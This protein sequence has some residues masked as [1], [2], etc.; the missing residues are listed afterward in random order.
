MTVV[1][2]TDHE[3]HSARPRATASG[4]P[5]SHDERRHADFVA[6]ADLLIH[7]AQYTAAEY[8]KQRGWGHSTGRIRRRRWRVAGK[9]AT[10]RALPPRSAA[11]RRRRR[12]DRRA[13]PANGRAEPA[14]RRLRGGRRPGDR[15]RRPI[16]DARPHARV[17]GGRRPATVPA[18]PARAQS[19]LMA[20]DDR[21]SADVLAAAVRADGGQL[22]DG[23]D[24]TARCSRSPRCSPSLVVVAAPVRRARSARAVP[25]GSARWRS[26][27]RAPAFVVVPRKRTWTSRPARGRRDRLAAS[28]RSRELYARTRISAGCCAAPAGGCRR[29]SASDEEQRLRALRDLR[30]ARHPARGALRPAHAARRRA[31]RRADRAGQPGRPRP[32]VVQV[33]PRPRVRET[34]RETRRSAPT[35]SSTARSASWPTRSSTRASPTTRSSPATRGCASTPGPARAADGSRVGTLCL[36]DRR[37]RQ[38]DAQQLGLLRDLA[39]LVE[40]ELVRPI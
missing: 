32:P 6:G 25:S 4:A 7:D 1:Y 38:L 34:P 16:A 40:A 33:A 3:P 29:R 10:A 13:G 37:A 15:A 23:A 28:G 27:A 17:V 21:P 14:P 2:A 19:V 39:D 24:A 9:R 35:R 31:V 18:E 30:R 22:V 20:V 36:I 8:A 26:P 12:R 5:Q 11:Q